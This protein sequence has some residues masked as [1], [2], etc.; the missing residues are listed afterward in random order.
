MSVILHEEFTKKLEYP[1]ILR[2]PFAWTGTIIANMKSNSTN[3]HTR[4]ILG[5]SGGKDST[6]LAILLHQEVPQME[7]FFCDTHREL[8]ETYEYLERIKAR[9]GIKIHYLSAER[10]F[11]HWL[12]VYGGALP[13]PQMRWCTKQL[14]IK[15]LEAF[16]GNDEA[17]SYIGIRADEHRDGYISTKPNIK[18]VLSV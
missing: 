3:N 13:S 2:L 16:I 5:L 14:K 12:D 6:A 9:L 8:P 1:S 18:A 4:H 17:V 7:Y 15:P 11:E 10:G